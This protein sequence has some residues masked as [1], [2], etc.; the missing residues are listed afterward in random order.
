MFSQIEKLYVVIIFGIVIYVVT[1]EGHVSPATG[2][3]GYTCYVY[4]LCLEG[5]RFDSEPGDRLSWCD[6]RGFTR[7]LQRTTGILTGSCLCI[8]THAMSA[9]VWLFDDTYF[10]LLSASLNEAQ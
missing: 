7:D 10:E 5:A 6:I 8:L 3:V 2:Y 9:V 1:R 4:D